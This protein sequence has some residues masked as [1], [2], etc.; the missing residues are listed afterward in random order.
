MEGNIPLAKKL[1]RIAIVLSVLV[2]GL[3]A[4][5]PPG[6]LDLGI[7]LSGLAGVNAV[8]NTGVAIFL[9]LALYFIRKKDVEK[10]RKMIYGAM[11]LSVIFLISYVLRRSTNGEIP[12]EETG[13]IK[14]I[15][16]IILISHIILAGLSLP[17]ILLTFIRGYTGQVQRHRKM[18][19]WVYPIWLYVAITGPVVYLMLYHW[20]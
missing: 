15:Y 19:K 18:A 12:F 20:N 7:D 17:F 10:H 14:T 4:F 5:V 16:L 1:N 3:V 2:V 6:I 11:I 13:I 8:L 9:L